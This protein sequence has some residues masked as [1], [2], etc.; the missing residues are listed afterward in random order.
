MTETL[1]SLS[2]TEALSKQKTEVQQQKIEINKNTPPKKV[3]SELLSYV[4]T[5]FG[6]NHIDSLWG[7]DI[8]FEKTSND[9]KCTKKNL[10]VEW[11]CIIVS[12]YDSS[13]EPYI[14]KQGKYIGKTSEEV[15]YQIWENWNWVLIQNNQTFDI[16]TEEFN[17]KVF[18]RLK[19]Y[20]SSCK[21][22]RP[23]AKVNKIYDDLE[24]AVYHK[25]SL[26]LGIQGLKKAL[27]NINS[28]KNQWD[29]IPDRISMPGTIN[30]GWLTHTE[31][32]LD[33]K[34]SFLKQ[35]DEL[36]KNREKVGD[37]ELTVG[38]EGLWNRVGNQAYIDKYWSP[39]REE[40]KEAEQ[41]FNKKMQ[42]IREKQNAAKKMDNTNR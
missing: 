16:T 1:N 12:K 17:T 24:K 6:D 18:P 38:R 29:S 19:W 37:V 9:S 2:K 20:L 31:S 28:L 30:L 36:E 32:M 11:A 26:N 13:I 35:M 25:Y 10:Y 14:D 3:I 41:Y 15:R 22:Q 39:Y 7:Y 8:N 27:D 4:K 23:P 42:E 34:I 40:D 21:E 33:A 5:E